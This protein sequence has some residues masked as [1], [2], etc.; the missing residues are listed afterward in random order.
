MNS[1]LWNN[2]KHLPYSDKPLKLWHKV[3]FVVMIA[4]AIIGSIL[5]HYHWLP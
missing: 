4:I 3:L 5:L 2:R 1:S